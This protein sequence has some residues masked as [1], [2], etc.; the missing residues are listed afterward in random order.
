[1]GR[2]KGPAAVLQTAPAY[3]FG[4]RCS[5]PSFQ[6]KVPGP[7]TYQPKLTSSDFLSSKGTGFGTSGRLAPYGKDL[8]FLVEGLETTVNLWVVCMQFPAPTGSSCCALL[9]SMQRA[10]H[11]GTA[12]HCANG[13]QRKLACAAIKQSFPAVATVV[14][15]A[16]Q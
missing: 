1:M 12:L 4:S 3:T 2:P 5:S 14:A 6:D 13:H 11:S 8:L 16:Q 15:C 9:F 10:A 7:G